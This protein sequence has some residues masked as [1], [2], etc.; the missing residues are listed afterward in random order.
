MIEKIKNFFIQIATL[1]P[2][3]SWF[4]GGIISAFLAIPF[5][6]CLQFIYSYLPHISSMGWFLIVLFCLISIGLALK[7]HKNEIVLDKFIGIMI[8]FFNIN[9]TFKVVCFGIIL[10][11]VL[12]F[13]IPKFIF[14]CDDFSEQNSSGHGRIIQ[15]IHLIIPSMLSGVIINIFLHFVLW[16][17]H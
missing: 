17:A 16:I 4:L 8:T 11:Y 13:L 14:K 10:F 6:Y 15:M 3:G 12:D 5:L 7:E 1:K 9:L 2:I